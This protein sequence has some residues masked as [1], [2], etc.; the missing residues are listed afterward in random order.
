MKI[1]IQGNTIRL[2]LNRPEVSEFERS[3]RVGSAIEFPDG[4][5]L[6]YALV[7]AGARVDA[8]FDTDEVQIRVPEAAARDWTGT[9]RVSIQDR[10]PLRAGSELEI[11]VEKDFQCMHKGEAGKDPNAY[12]NPMA[13]EGV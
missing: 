8:A 5:R 7:R 12:P 13:G 4:R 6:A 11:I 3:G 9:D 2:R 10:A 1:R